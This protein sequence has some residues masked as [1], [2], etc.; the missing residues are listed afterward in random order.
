MESYLR[1][2]AVPLNMRGSLR[3]RARRV[4]KDDRVQRLTPGI[5]PLCRRIVLRFDDYHQAHDI[6]QWQR[7]LSTFD[8]AGMRGLVSVPPYVSDEPLA[9][10]HVRFLRDLQ[11]SG[12]EIAQHGHRHVDVVDADYRSEFRGRPFAEQHHAVGAGLDR[13]RE[14]GLEPRTFVPPW[15]QFDRTTVRALAAHGFDCLNEGRWPLPRRVD[16]V[17]L[18]PT[19]PPGLHPDTLA[20]GVLTLVGHPHLDDDPTAFIDRVGPYADRV[21]TPAEVTDWWAR[22][23]LRA[24]LG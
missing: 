9:P 2:R 1:W 5:T 21:A 18:V 4:V 22:G 20:V 24:L 3:E 15:H 11:A 10:E 14:L 6:E 23:P 13:L 8:D 7:T 16:G 17:T 19:H 12:W